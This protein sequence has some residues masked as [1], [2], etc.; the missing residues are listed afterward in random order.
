MTYDHK[1]TQSQRTAQN[2]PWGPKVWAVRP[3]AGAKGSRQRDGFLLLMFY[4][5]KFQT[6]RKVERI[7]PRGSIL[8]CLLYLRDMSFVKKFYYGKF[9]IHKKME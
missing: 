5:E 8:P 6:Y 1:T 2:G 4:L 7:V 9:Q 3:P